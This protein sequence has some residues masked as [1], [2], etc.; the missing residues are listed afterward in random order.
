MVPR[1]GSARRTF[2]Q[3]PHSGKSQVEDDRDPYEIQRQWEKENRPPHI[4]VV[5][6]EEYLQSFRKGYA[7]DPEFKRYYQE[8][9]KDEGKDSWYP[10]QRFFKDDRGLLFFRNASFEPRLCVPKSER[11]TLLAQVHEAP[12]ETAHAGP[13]KLWQVLAGRFYW[14]RMKKDVVNF[15]NTCDVCQKTKHRNFNKYGK[16]IS[17]PVPLKPY[18]SVSLDLITGLPLVDGFNAILVIVDRLSKHAQFIATVTALTTAGFAE[19]FV[20][21]VV[22]RFGIPDDLIADRDRRWTSDFWREV[23]RFLKV[24]L[25]LSSSRHPMHDGQTEIVNQRLEI[26]LRAYVQEDKESWPQWLHLLEHA[27]NCTPQDSINA[28]PY[29]VLYGFQPK[30][31]SDFLLPRSSSPAPQAGLVYS[32]D[33]QNFIAAIQLHRESARTAIARAQVKQS[34]SYNRGRK[35]I[36][37]KD[38][39]QVL[40]NPH[41]L[42]WLESKGEGAKLNPRALGPFT[43]RERINPKVYRLEMDSRF[44]GSNVF[45]LDHLRKYESPSEEFGPRTKLPEARADKIPEATYEVEKIV[46]HSK[47]G[48]G[49]KKLH[50]LVRWKGY[51]TT[52][53]TWEPE[54]GLTN[55]RIALREYKKRAGLA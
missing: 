10:G 3:D 7:Q 16:L 24:R 6:E 50:Y 34:E 13:A 37:F 25:A 45:N 30:Q 12:Y 2:S 38:G 53:D 54:S 48:K 11:G 17:N 44:P 27:Y 36:E 35:E 31:P 9:E 19:L 52:Y 26:M 28:S 23:A 32:G 15:C 40:I 22:C 41:S 51:D 47:R 5:I 20:R 18:E 33:T 1:E 43:V 46:G 29:L 49:K 21:Y 42:E 14:K 4:H 55:A 8:L 39:D